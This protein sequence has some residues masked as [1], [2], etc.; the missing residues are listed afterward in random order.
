MFLLSIC[1]SRVRSNMDSDRI[2]R[3]C[4]FVVVVVVVDRI[5]PRAAVFNKEMSAL[6]S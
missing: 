2:G 3:Q 1:S 6:C 5:S 4:Q